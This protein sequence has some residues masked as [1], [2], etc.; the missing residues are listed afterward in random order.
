MVQQLSSQHAPACLSFTHAIV[1]SNFA[2]EYMRAVEQQ[3]EGPSRIPLH[4]DMIKVR[5]LPGLPP[6]SNG[7]PSNR[8]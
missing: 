5:A 3:S 2:L 6:P 4:P 1:F 8:R 7:L